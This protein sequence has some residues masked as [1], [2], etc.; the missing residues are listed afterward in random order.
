MASLPSRVGTSSGLM[1]GWSLSAALPPGLQ[2]PVSALCSAACLPLFAEALNYR[3]LSVRPLPSPQQLSSRRSAGGVGKGGSWPRS[4]EH[5]ASP[6]NPRPHPWLLRS[7]SGTLQ[8]RSAQLS[9][10][11]GSSLPTFLASTGPHQ[12]PT[13]RP[14]CFHPLQQLEQCSQRPTCWLSA[15]PTSLQAQ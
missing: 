11:T 12:P 2:H 8:R 14:S 13:S 6:A 7:A 9:A 5:Q 10:L 1:G 15:P 4:P 3:Q